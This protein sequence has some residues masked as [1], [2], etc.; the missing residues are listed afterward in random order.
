[1]TGKLLKRTAKLHN[2]VYNV[3]FPVWLLFL[4]PPLILVSLLV[5][6]LVDSAVIIFGLRRIGITDWKPIYKTTWW[7][8][9]LLGFLADIIGAVFLGLI[10][11]GVGSLLPYPSVGL[12]RVLDDAF[13]AVM[14]NPFE[15]PL[16]LL[17][18]VLA[19][20]LVGWLIYVFNKRVFR[21]A[22]LE[23]DQVNRMARLLAFW[24]APYFFLLPLTPFI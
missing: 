18:V 11:L 23:P 10:T 14:Y 13:T 12:S 2:Q 9:W 8:V 5:N 1:M 22:G 24:T 7:K 3:F 16:A 6:F 17:I 20:G 21:R 19:I 15:H 4:F